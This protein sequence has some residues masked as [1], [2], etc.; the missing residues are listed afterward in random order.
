MPSARFA[1]RQVDDL[2]LCQFLARI[3]EFNDLRRAIPGVTQH[4]LTTGLREFDQHGIWE[5][6]VFAEAPPRV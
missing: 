6:E 1:R 4:M 2:I 3:C 5:R